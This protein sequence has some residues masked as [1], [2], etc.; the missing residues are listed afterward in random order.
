VYD[1]GWL[2]QFRPPAGGRASPQPREAGLP[3]LSGAE[4]GRNEDA[5]QLWDTAQITGA[6][7]RGSWPLYLDS[8][9]HRQACL[10]AVLRD[11]FVLISDVPREPNA[12]L[13]VAR[14][15]GLVRETERGQ[16]I[17]IR[18]GAAPPSAAATTR[19]L[20]PCTSSPFR[21]P[22][23]TV[24]VVSCLDDA[25]E[26]GESTLVD[27][28]CAASRLRAERPA[29]FTAM[30]STPVTFVRADARAELRA[31][32][33][34][35]SVDPRGR[36]REIRFASRYLSPL[37]G[38]AGEIAAFYDAYRSFAQLVRDP[39]LAVTFRLRPGD[40]LVLDN[41]RVLHGRTAFADTGHRHLQ[42]CWTDL[43]GLASR[44][45]VLERRQH[46]GRSRH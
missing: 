10:R 34:V 41:T 4:D 38:P 21:D 19:S 15:I 11:G 6:F 42:A 1:A 32:R 28:F 13:A 40:C 24:M 43:D 17:D 8:D 27:G 35:V 2:A 30:A 37:R 25:S 31:T 23:L 22:L 5:K 33:P 16:V 9:A 44:L 12:V 29:A 3:D 18:V 20:L 45:A 46:N 26:G 7:P 36:I 39:E 14:S